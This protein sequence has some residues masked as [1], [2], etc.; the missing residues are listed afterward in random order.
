MARARDATPP[1][2]GAFLEVEGR[3]WRRSDPGIPSGL[4]QQLVDELMAARRAVGTAADANERREARRRVQDAKVA[5]GERGR[6][7]WLDTAPADLEPRIE[8]AILALLRSRQDGATICPSEP[9]RIVDGRSWRRLLP[10]VRERAVRLARAGHIEILRDRVPASGDLT[11]GV[12][13]Y[14]L[15]GPSPVRHAPVAATDERRG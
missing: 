2:E 15:T 10:V 7:W 3:K 9:A 6:A 11:K 8:A 12:L 4:R 5:L 13:R 1:P 14:R